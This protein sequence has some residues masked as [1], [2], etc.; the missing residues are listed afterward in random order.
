MF[1]YTYRKKVSFLYF[2]FLLKCA[3]IGLYANTLLV[4]SPCH[5][6]ENSTANKKKIK[7]KAQQSY[8]SLKYS[9]LHTLSQTATVSQW[10]IIISVQLGWGAHF[11]E[12][13][14]TTPRKTWLMRP[15]H[16]PWAVGST[17][18]SQS[19]KLMEFSPSNLYGNHTQNQLALWHWWFNNVFTWRN[20]KHIN[21][22]KTLHR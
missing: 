15:W 12:R 11:K 13:T 1:I 8:L 3:T 22:F 19:R 17:Q 6:E 2:L 14:K 9:L 18:H 16:S 7:K 5:R 20:K 21:P 10:E 4:H